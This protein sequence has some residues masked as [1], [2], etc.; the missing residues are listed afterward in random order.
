MKTFVLSAIAVFTLVSCDK[1]NKEIEGQLKQ[2]EKKAAEAVERQR[3]LE[4]ALTEQRLLA[5]RDAIERERTLIEQ[6]WMAMERAKE[7][8]NA[9]G[10]AEL[11]KRRSELA[12]RER[13]LSEVRDDL[14]SREQELTGMEGKLSERELDLAGRKPLDV[15]SPIERNYVSGA[16]GDFGN[17]YEPLASYGSWF[18]TRDYGYVYQPTVVR[19]VTWRPYTRGRWAFTNHGWTWVSSEPFGWACYHYGR[20][21]Y[22]RNFGWVWVPGSQ[23]APA[24]V[25]WRESPGYIGWAPLPPETFVWRS[26]YW[27][28]S[29]DTTYGIS[30]SWYSFVSY[31]HFGGYIQRYCVPVSQNVVIYQNTTN[32]T[33]YSIR[34]ERVFVGGPSYRNVSERI[35]RDFPIH[36]LRMDQSPDFG[37]GG[38]TLNSQFSG[39]EL[40]VVA[41][42][43]DAEWNRALRPSR[44]SRDLGEVQVERPRELSEEIRRPFRE[45]IKEESQRAERLIRESGG[46][47]NF[48]RERKTRLERGRQEIADPDRNR[49][50]G[51]DNEI[52]PKVVPRVATP[53]EPTVQPPATE[54]PSSPNERPSRFHQPNK[55]DAVPVVPEVPEISQTAPKTN[56]LVPSVP[57][58]EI[59]PNRSVTLPTEGLDTSEN[60][61][62]PAIAPPMPEPSDKPERHWVPEVPVI[63][64]TPRTSDKSDREVNLRRAQRQAEEQAALERLRQQEAARLEERQR[65]DA[66][67]MEQRQQE[68]TLRER[69]QAIRVE[70]QQ[71]RRQQQQEERRRQ[72]EQQVQQEMLRREQQEEARKIQEQ[73]VREQREIQRRQMEEQQERVRQEQEQMERARKQQEEAQRIREEQMERAR[74]QGG[75]PIR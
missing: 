41:P 5:E 49:V 21:A 44:V 69:E 66:I 20:W 15:F 22:L 45:Q 8:G 70:E 72:Q 1:S 10:E 6:E 62:S 33:N 31:R 75:N 54:I 34:G 27:S 23:W 56:Q 67:K 60:L 13:R 39:D 25:T 36:R 40:R 24:W 11:A 28:S 53:Q 50:S 73:Q 38:R 58:F 14:D 9:A 19:E 64:E 65:E 52:D 12:E 4:A 61:E 18:H 55:R 46:S 29:I 30:S 57:N 7:A 26:G 16:T 37:R 35:G 51:R 63:S 43:M 3:Q 68:R 48:E 71:M 47:E 17:F 42:R 74:M 32:I 59:V 2:L